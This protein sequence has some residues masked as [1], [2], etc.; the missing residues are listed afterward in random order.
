M[1]SPLA[2][3]HLCWLAHCSS[4]S[5]AGRGVHQKPN[6]SEASHTAPR[7]AG[8]A[9]MTTWN[10]LTSPVDVSAIQ[11]HQSP[12]SSRAKARTV[13]IAFRMK[14]SSQV[15]PSLADDASRGVHVC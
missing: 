13:L 5:A 6:Q 14:I 4:R 10:T 15:R 11:H 3:S 7:K 1:G 8:N 12:P 9:P 2:L